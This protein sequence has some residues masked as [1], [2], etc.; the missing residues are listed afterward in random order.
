MSF[1]NHFWHTKHLNTTKLVSYKSETKSTYQKFLLSKSLY[2]IT[3]QTTNQKSK[4]KK[5]LFIVFWKQLLCSSIEAWINSS[6]WSFKSSKNVASSLFVFRHDAIGGFG[7]ADATTF[8][9]SLLWAA[10]ITVTKL[11]PINCIYS[12]SYKVCMSFNNVEN[13]TRLYLK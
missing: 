9:F 11:L 8:S 4:G 7:L 3:K 1:C 6:I 5:T 13:K 2:S 12:L 10:I